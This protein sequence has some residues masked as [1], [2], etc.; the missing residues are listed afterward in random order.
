MNIEEVVGYYLDGLGVPADRQAAI[1]ASFDGDLDT[2]ADFAFAVGGID[3]L[4]YPLSINSGVRETKFGPFP[5]HRWAAAFLLH[6]PTMLGESPDNEDIRE[7]AQEIFAMYRGTITRPRPALPRVLGEVQRLA[8][9][10]VPISY[11]QA[12]HPSDAPGPIPVDEIL[13]YWD[14]GVPIEYALTLRGNNA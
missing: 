2:L 6:F 13:T 14:A 7:W 11:I 12:L 1:V 3:I 8:K 5:R 4:D 9:A 10:G